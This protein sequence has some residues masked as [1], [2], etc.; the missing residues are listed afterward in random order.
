[1]LNIISLKGEFADAYDGLYN[2][3]NMMID[4]N[5]GKFNRAMSLIKDQLIGLYSFNKGGYVEVTE[6]TGEEE[7][8]DL[9]EI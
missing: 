7:I 6:A 9:R 2:P 8:I 4:R 1:M 5:N 3:R